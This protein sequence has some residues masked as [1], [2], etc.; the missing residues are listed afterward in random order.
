[1]EDR[2]ENMIGGDAHGPERLF[3]VEVAFG[4]DGLIAALRLRALEDV[5]AHTG[6]A[7]FQLGKP[8]GAI[9]GPYTIGAV[10]YEAICVSTNKTGQIAVRGFGQSPTNFAL[11][12]AIDKVARHLGR[13]RLEVR[14]RNFIRKEQFPYRIPSGSEYD[15]GDYRTV[16][17]KAVEL[18]DLPE[19]LA[20]RDELREQG[21]LAGIGIATCLEPGGGNSS[22]EPL[23]NPKNQTTTWPESCRITVGSGGDVTA[24]ITTSSS[25]Q[26]HETLAATVVGEELDLP[27][28][29]IRVLHADSLSGLP[30]NSPV[31]S[32][33]AIM[34]GGAAAGAARR[35][36]DQA[37]SIAAH[38]LAADPSELLLR[39]GMIRHRDDPAR[40]IA[41]HD[42]ALIAHR[43]YHRMPP[44]MEPGLQASFVWEVPTGGALPDDQERIQMYPCYSFAAHIV[45]ASIDPDSGQ[46]SLPHYAIAH[47]CGTVINPDIVKGM[48][49]GGTAH[50]IGAAL[51][52]VFAYDA[53]GQMNSGS[54]MDYLLPSAHEVPDIQMAEH[55]TPS[56]LTS[57]GQKGVGEGGYLGAPAAVASAVND[58]LAARGLEL[59]R[60]PMR[61]VDIEALLHGG[62]GEP[63]V[64]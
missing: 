36:R 54:L 56:P 33:M 24:L 20:R 3:D 45:L 2:L 60:L 38:N 11:E 50:G 18:A 40:R 48:V 51:Y 17:D 55:C 15:S 5:G 58:A 37:L 13:D 19:L 32:R 57:H 8:V 29:G 14:K 44:G 43:H 1:I 64:A 61:P 41:W 35:I 42:V 30:G 12:T 4:D 10:R 59:C 34:L 63:T 53:A 31:G 7:P 47:D 49:L 28:E 9:V 62:G 26:G 16:L 22:F 46:V 21:L 39:D 52:E 25:G 27:P 23:L 6:R